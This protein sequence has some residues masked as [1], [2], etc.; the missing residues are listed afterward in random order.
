MSA[1]LSDFR[2]AAG[3]AM[4][5]ILFAAGSARA[6]KLLR[7][8][9]QPGENRNE[10][11]V[12]EM[13]Q[14]LR[15]AG[16]APPMLMTTTQTMDLVV[17][18]ESVDEQGTAALFQTIERMQMK[19]Q[20]AQ[21]VMLEFDSAA[22]KEP[23]GMAKMLTPLL[24]A[25]IK[26]PMRL[27][28]TTRGEVRDMKLP[29]GMLESMNKV[30]GGGQ[31]GNLFSP[32]WMKQMIEIAVLP[33]GPVKPGDTWTRKTT[34]KNPV[35]GE[36]IVESTFC[37]EGTETRNGKTLDKITFTTAFKAA[38]DKK[39]GIIGIK[40]Q[41]TSGTVYLDSASGR[42]AGGVATTKMK[43]DIEVFGQKMGQDME[44]KTT[45]KPQP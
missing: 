22:G 16:D 27:Q 1:R 45:F 8:K 11:I 38:G 25:M 26:K 42:I 43:M 23:E 34:V 44:M 18:V 10:Q 14:T 17:R 41:A 15:P 7:L 3:V 33:E 9:F 28:T 19:V 6:E 24:E 39:E 20:S 2:R 36:Q 35:L 13:R 12:Q 30:G 40:E 32:D 5:L 29:Q 21:G 37:Y 4:A 31:A